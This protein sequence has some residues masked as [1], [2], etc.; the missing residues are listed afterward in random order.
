MKKALNEVSGLVF[1]I[2]CLTAAG[3]DLGYRA[4]ISLLASHLFG[5]GV[6]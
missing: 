6:Q 2:G 1:T 3:A 5:S 4:S